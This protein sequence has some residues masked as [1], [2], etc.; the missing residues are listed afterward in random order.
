MRHNK[1]WLHSQLYEIFTPR[2]LF[3]YR[4]QIIDQL[5]DVMGD[6]KVDIIGDDIEKEEEKERIEDEEEEALLGAN[7][8]TF[9][10]EDLDKV[11]KKAS[12]LTQAIIKF[13]IMR[14]RF[15]QKVTLELQKVVDMMRKPHCLFCR[16]TQ[17]VKVEIINN[18]EDLFYRFLKAK[19]QNLVS[20]K[21]V[22]W[23]RYFVKKGS[24]RTICTSCHRGIELYN[25]E[26]VAKLN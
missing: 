17:G 12:P 3:L 19:K 21:I 13:W 7:K 24:T 25:K 10:K 6:I 18:V 23:Q 4:D 15:R 22:D 9:K 8:Y 2:T 20:Y 26:I 11:R 1:P 5:R 14:A 16:T